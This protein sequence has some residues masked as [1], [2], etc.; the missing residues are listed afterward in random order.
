[1]VQFEVKGNKS[2]VVVEAPCVPSICQPLSGQNILLAKR[3]HNHLKGLY[4]ADYNTN[5]FPVGI[6]IGVD[7]YSFFQA[8]LKVE[9]DAAT[10]SVYI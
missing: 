9:F 5:L 7:Y 6:L 2:K 8:T 1:V 10:H 3:Q 4:L